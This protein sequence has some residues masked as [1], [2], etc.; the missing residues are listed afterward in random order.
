[1]FLNE[2]NVVC[3]VMGIHMIINTENGAVVGVDEDGLEQYQRLSEVSASVPTDQALY[4]FLMENEFISDSPFDKNRATIM[5][6]YIHVTNKCNLHCL[7]CYSDNE[8]R[9]KGDDLSTEEMMRVLDELRS[10][11]VENLVISGG[12]PLFRKD[13]VDLV[14]HAKESCGIERITL[15]TNG[16]VGGREIYTGL[17][18][19]LD[20][21]AVSLDTY[22][23]EC[24]FKRR[25][26]F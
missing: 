20:T 18:P 26:D 5:T 25:R 2:N 9:N 19:Y 8:A 17:A 16:T 4:Q 13:I 14:K 6:A 21:M 10:A 23:P 15:I 24:I 22:A 7:G 12:E 3:D 1:M 11:G